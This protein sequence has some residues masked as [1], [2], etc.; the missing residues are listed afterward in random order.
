ME[1]TGVAGALEEDS[2]PGR[3]AA[4][5]AGDVVVDVR[6]VSKRYEIY[7]RPVDRLKQTLWRGRVR[8][9]R[10]F[11]ALRDVDLDLRRGQAL[12][13]IGRNGSGKSTLLQIIA[14]TLRPTEGTVIVR[15]RVHALLELGSGFNHEFTGRENVF[16]NGAILGL[17]REQVAARFDDI[18]SFADIGD[19]LDRPIKE[20]STG[21]VVRLAFAVQVQLSPDVLVVDEALAVGDEKFQRKCYARLEELQAAGVSV[22][23]VTHSTEVVLKYCQRAILLEGGRVHGSGASKHIVDQ[24]HALLYADEQAYL[25]WL[26]RS[27]EPASALAPQS[28]GARDAEKAD[29]PAALAPVGSS[30]P[31]EDARALIERAWV[32]DATGAPRES[33]VTG[34]EAEIGFSVRVL[35]DLAAM[36]AGIRI[37]TVEGVEVYGTSTRYLG[38]SLV[39]VAAGTVCR[40]TFRMRLLLGAGVYFVSVAV[41]E[42]RQ[43]PD[44]RYLDK[45]SDI[46]IVR[47]Q[48]HPVTGTGIAH[49]HA[50]VAFSI[51][52][53]E[54]SG[55]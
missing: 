45:R 46:L 31:G 27:T 36:Q 48:E 29:V 6:G 35:Q 41:A 55:R 15:G 26:G 14:G 7:G 25:R 21:M 32:T 50:K 53:R 24:Y 2:S 47:I 16:L 33:F 42:P 8:F 22:L 34:A 5:A 13:I 1:G 43:G 30:E 3:A 18:A 4:G 52:R 11:W 49:L 44:M 37:R 40:A 38:A 23:L 20:Y 17:P 28:E 39:D 9:Y 12:G 51:E 54:E 10:E 19:F